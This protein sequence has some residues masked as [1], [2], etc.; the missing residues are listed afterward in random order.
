[1][2]NEHIYAARKEIFYWTKEHVQ[3]SEP[4][5]EL[6][7][8]VGWFRQVGARNAVWLYTWPD[9]EHLHP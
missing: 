8:W 5:E 6:I 9:E 7:P 4:H 3:P 2:K 1:M